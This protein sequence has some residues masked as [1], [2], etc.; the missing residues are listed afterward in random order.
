MIARIYMRKDIGSEI[1]RTNGETKKLSWTCDSG[2]RACDSAG[3][4]TEANHRPSM[5]FSK[6][7]KGLV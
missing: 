5:S 4:Y 6:E 1:G 3:R 2:H 7:I